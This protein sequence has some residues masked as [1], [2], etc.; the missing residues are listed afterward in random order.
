MRKLGQSHFQTLLLVVC[1]LLTYSINAQ[2][3]N[4]KIKADLSIQ[5]I[6]EDIVITGIAH[7]KTEVT[8]SISYKLS[9][10]KSNLEDP[11]ANK[12][13]NVQTGRKVLEGFQTMNLS[14]TRINRNT[15]DRLIILLL[16]YDENEKLVG[17]SRH[18]INDNKDKELIKQEF[19]T[20]L[21]SDLEQ[22]DISYNKIELKGIV[23][24]QTKTKA[25]RDFYQLFYSNYL[26]YN[27]N[28]EHIITISELI[29]LG[30]NTKIN[31]S[32]L[33]QII[34]TFFVKTQYDYLKSMSDSA[35]NRTMRYLESLK[36][37][38]QRIKTF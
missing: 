20:M 25:G 10:I 38:E 17:T 37:D 36:R 11:N 18:V 16:I 28:S 5:E 2:I 14:T 8:Q 34:F 7:N 32:I 6:P 1:T 26:S 13:T 29:T 4:T 21:D 12:A 9:V 24:D 19:T 35:L 15:K 22:E 23:V 31:V 3:L 30:N 33:D 27:I